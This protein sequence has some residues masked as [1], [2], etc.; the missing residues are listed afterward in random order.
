MPKKKTGSKPV[1]S[2][3]ELVLKNIPLADITADKDVQARVELDEEVIGDYAQAMVEGVKFPP[4]IVF[5]DGSTK[6]LS[7]GFHRFTAAIHTGGKITHLY[8]EVREGGKRDAQ[9]YACGANATHGLRPTQED[10]RKAVTRLLTDP[11]WGKWADREIARQ[12]GVSHP[13]VATVRG[14]LAQADGA[15]GAGE[16]EDEGRKYRD[17]HGTESVMRK[18]R[19]GKKEEA[20]DEESAKR[21]EP[22]K[23]EESEPALPDHEE[24]SDKEPEPN[25]P[26][27]ARSVEEHHEN[28]QIEALRKTNETLTRDKRALEARV[29][30]LE[31][32]AT[33]KAITEAHRKF[34]ESLEAHRAI[35]AQRDSEI[36][37]LKA[38]AEPTPTE[39]QSLLQLFKRAVDVLASLDAGANQLNN[40]PDKI[41]ERSRSKH[42]GEVRDML[43]R[44]RGLRD[45]VK[46]HVEKDL[47]SDGS[48]KLQWTETRSD[49]GTEFWAAEG[50]VVYS[51]VKNADGDICYELLIDGN[52]ANVLSNAEDALD[53]NGD[54]LREMKEYAEEQFKALTTEQPKGAKR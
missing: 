28:L 39:P 51:P 16:A 44:L 54:L 46:I 30:E 23:E 29:T 52:P 38:R 25:T 15:A 14:E 21:E 53:K 31:A 42:A 7:E 49:L 2:A 35:I 24:R 12:C 36:A 50:R 43:R 11:E 18:R 22:A 26:P 10:K 47:G 17:K 19:A 37:T 4:C 27:V 1:K 48:A 8:C 20:S 9:L 3:A 33:S 13:F 34:E 32:G 5:D 41:T 45:R 6:W 40:W